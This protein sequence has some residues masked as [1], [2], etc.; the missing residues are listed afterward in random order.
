M[1]SK[2]ESLID[3]QIESNGLFK[4]QKIKVSAI[5]L[6]L[7]RFKRQVS[8]FGY[9]LG[10]WGDDN[11]VASLSNY[12]FSVHHHLNSYYNHFYI[13]NDINTVEAA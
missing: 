4:L 2:N 11:F 5:F 10:N 6:M 7:G 8:F 1:T 12:F 3:C 13:W 9:N